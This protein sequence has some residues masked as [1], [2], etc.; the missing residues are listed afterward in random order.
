MCCSASL[1]YLWPPLSA[2]EGGAGRRGGGGG[3]KGR[4][5]CIG[6]FR[7]QQCAQSS[8]APYLEL[9]RRLLAVVVLVGENGRAMQ[10]CQR[11]NL[12]DLLCHLCLGLDSN[13][14]SGPLRGR[15]TTSETRSWATTPFQFAADMHRAQW[16]SHTQPAQSEKRSGDEPLVAMGARPPNSIDFAPLSLPLPRGP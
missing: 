13:C 10:K 12:M 6:L 11:S 2:A 9:R 1:F 5:R 14:A 15:G 3:G 4:A 7:P 8:G 16:R